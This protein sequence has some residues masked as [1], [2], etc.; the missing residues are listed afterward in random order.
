MEELFD[1]NIE[2]VLEHWEIKHAIREIISNALDEQMLSNTKD[3]EIY[4]KNGSWI[5]RDFGRG[6]QNFHFTQNENKEKMLAPNLIGK[7]GVGLKDALVVF[8]RKNIKITINSKYAHI[9]TQ[10]SNKKGFNIQ[11]LHAVFTDSTNIN[12]EGTEFIMTGVTKNEIE[13]AKSMFLKF[14]KYNE[15]LEKTKYGEVYKNSDKISN[16]Y[17]NGVLVATEEN[18]LFS[19]NI[20]NISA[21]IKKAL[22]RERTNVGRTAYSDS[23][24]NILKN[25][26]SEIVLLQLVNDIENIVRGTNK[27]ESNWID[28]ASCAATNLNK[29]GNVV[30]M[31]PLQRSMLTNEQIEILEE[32]GK[33]LVFI[34]DNLYEKMSDKLITFDN[35]YDQYQESFKYEFVEYN[36]LT[37]TEREV[38]DDREILIQM[39][40]DYGLDVQ[41]IPIKISESIR[42]DSYGNSTQG[43]YDS[44]NNII[45][46]RRDTLSSQTVFYGVL[47]H[48]LMHYVTGYSD[49]TR[50]FENSLTKLIGYLIKQNLINSS[51]GNN[52][53]KK[54]I[55]SFFIK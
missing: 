48:E 41:N 7:F 43:V 1:L 5:I 38:F 55:F 2:K 49:C 18:F 52:K 34:T 12:M 51:E 27:D 14:A 53:S 8:Y 26:K 24:K 35:V 33:R 20:T 54:N 30:F 45:V 39:F 32:S 44:L 28:V 40:L 6:I 3:I 42:V 19:Y 50:E 36:R 29:S 10:M 13:E 23:I 4:E 25:C 16:I 31:T 47:A 11:T 22:N 37:K 21:Q 46:I 15:P 9:T 17:I